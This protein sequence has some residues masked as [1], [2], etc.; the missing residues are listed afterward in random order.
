MARRQGELQQADALGRAVLSISWRSGDRSMI[1]KGLDG[2][3]QT[4]V[5]LCVSGDIVQGIR[6]ARLFGATATLRLT[7]GCQTSLPSVMLQEP[8]RPWHVRR[9]AKRSGSQHSRLARRSPW[10]KPSLKP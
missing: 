4:A 3:A 6:A 1:A 8:L 10:M 5:A 2:L 9:W 7:L